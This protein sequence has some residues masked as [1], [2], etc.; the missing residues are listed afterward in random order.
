[1][2]GKIG[3]I[4]FIEFLCRIIYARFSMDLDANLLGSSYVRLTTMGSTIK[5]NM[6]MA[7]FSDRNSIVAS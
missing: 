4:E 7:A 6:S 3:F 1:V 2:Y 5:D